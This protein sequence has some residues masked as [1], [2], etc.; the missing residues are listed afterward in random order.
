M[1]TATRRRDKVEKGRSGRIV[2]GHAPNFG[3]K[4]SEDRSAYV[5]DEGMMPV[6]H[7]IL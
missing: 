1:Q 5:V 6:V 3:F 7:R 2:G 4:F